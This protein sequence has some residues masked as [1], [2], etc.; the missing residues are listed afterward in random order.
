MLEGQ[1]RSIW[2]SLK[3]GH[4]GTRS[5]SRSGCTTGK[6]TGTQPDPTDRNRTIKDRLHP[7][8]VGCRLR[9][10]PFEKFSG[11]VK[12]RLQPVATGLQAAN[13]T[14]LYHC[15]SYGLLFYSYFIRL[16]IMESKIFIIS[17]DQKKKK[18]VTNNREQTVLPATSIFTTS[19]TLWRRTQSKEIKGN[20]L[21]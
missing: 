5:V 6:K 3:P 20:K 1:M 9:L 12:N 7:V 4:C 18:R 19:T 10:H 16:Q 15:I 8:A 13:S 11:P 2:V 21:P 14:H 17:R